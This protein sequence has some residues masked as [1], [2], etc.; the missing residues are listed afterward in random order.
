MSAAMST[1]EALSAQPALTIPPLS[2][3]NSLT[4]SDQQLVQVKAEPNWYDTSSI[5]S[6]PCEV[7]DFSATLNLEELGKKVEAISIKNEPPHEPEMVTAV[8]LPV[9]RR[10]VRR[11]IAL[12]S[13]SQWPRL[14]DQQLYSNLL[15]QPP[16]NGSVQ[17]VSYKTTGIVGKRNID[18]QTLVS[19]VRASGR[20]L[21]EIF[22]QQ[23]KTAIGHY[24]FTA[25]NE[26]Y[27]CYDIICNWIYDGIL[28]KELWLRLLTDKRSA[29]YGQERFAFVCFLAVL[30][31]YQHKHAK[32][33]V[34]LLDAIVDNRDC[35]GPPALHFNTVPQNGMSVYSQC[36]TIIQRR[37][38]RRPIINGGGSSA[39]VLAT[40]D[41]NIYEL[42][43]CIVAK[44]VQYQQQTCHD[45][46][47]PYE[48]IQAYFDAYVLGAATHLPFIELQEDADASFPLFHIASHII[49]RRA[50]E[51][52][53]PF[54]D[55]DVYIFD[56]LPY[57]FAEYVYSKVEVKSELKELVVLKREG[58]TYEDGSIPSIPNPSS[59]ANWKAFASRL[60]FVQ[61]KVEGAASKRGGSGTRS[62]RAHP[63]IKSEPSTKTNDVDSAVPVKE[64]ASGTKKRRTTKKNAKDEK[65]D[66]DPTVPNDPSTSSNPSPLPKN[67]GRKP[68][69]RSN[70]KEGKEE[71]KTAKNAES[72][73][74]APSKKK[75]QSRQHTSKSSE[76]GEGS[77]E[78]GN[79]RRG[80]RDDWVQT[81]GKRRKLNPKSSEPKLSPP[82]SSSSPIL[83]APILPDSWIPEL[84]PHTIIDACHY[85]I[86]GQKCPYSAVTGTPHHPACTSKLSD[87]NLSPSDFLRS[88]GYGQSDNGGLDGGEL[89][90][91][92]LP[93]LPENG[94]SNGPSSYHHHNHQHH[95]Q[96]QHHQNHSYLTTTTTT[97]T[98]TTTGAGPGMLLPSL[99]IDENSNPLTSLFDNGFHNNGSSGAVSSSN[100]D[101]TAHD[102]RTAQIKTTEEKYATIK[103]KHATADDK[104]AINANDLISLGEGV[105]EAEDAGVE[106]DE[107]DYSSDEESE[108][109]CS[110]ESHSIDDDKGQGD[111]EDEESESV[112]VR[113]LASIPFVECQYCHMYSKKTPRHGKCLRCGDTCRSQCRKE[114][115]PEK[116]AA[117]PL[118]QLNNPR[119]KA[120]RTF[121]SNL[122]ELP[123]GD[124][125]FE[126][127]H[128]YIC[129]HN[130]IGN[131][132]ME[133]CFVCRPPVIRFCAKC[134]LHGRVNRHHMFIGL[135]RAENSGKAKVRVAY[136]NHAR[137]LALLRAGFIKTEGEESTLKREDGSTIK[138]T[139]RRY[140]R[141]DQD[142]PGNSARSRDVFYIDHEDL[143]SA[144]LRLNQR[145]A[146]M[147]S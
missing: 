100:R 97:T 60:G 67:T 93:T 48:P 131:K 71:K 70:T 86:D 87:P 81:K 145:N 78:A 111:G 8:T 42:L 3:S 62:S 38:Q 2:S 134:I 32:H 36:S 52:G 53:A 4:N 27:M 84:P 119:S 99:I 116:R 72:D 92:Q 137:C 24:F 15:E 123:E 40:D 28:S 43:F 66:A 34:V 95:G 61:P 140:F 80:T 44:V 88:S 108:V 142:R 104:H 21:N 146:A 136:I 45:L 31:H 129:A 26:T 132:G 23:G 47:I 37:D 126:E 127:A 12:S 30:T 106:G 105:D 75:R 110:H 5:N 1:E 68:R 50:R 89:F 9:K 17:F 19:F 133:N 118:R 39:A 35:V 98:A 69:Q 33:N 101:S 103:D 55:E 58:G 143:P 114:K 49:H 147:F 14:S 138:V 109:G 64:E 6:V 96:H 11:N 25:C 139:Q 113:P 124:P 83:Q 73:T 122:L 10:E 76:A 74:S 125:D 46:R 144:I 57:G 90:E 85:T 65:S 63:V 82:P 135:M 91:M 130:K 20:I 128:A 56:C 115:K 120:F 51:P 77:I 107:P 121:L 112:S 102:Y 13:S 59:T 18:E 7:I 141:N 16:P 94:D 54:S 79:G 29:L 117:V 41:A 22:V